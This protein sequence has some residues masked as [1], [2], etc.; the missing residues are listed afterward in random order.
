MANWVV[1]NRNDG[2]MKRTGHSTR[3]VRLVIPKFSRVLSKNSY[4]NKLG[5]LIIAELNEKK[6]GALPPPF[7]SERQRCISLPLLLTRWRFSPENQP[8][9]TL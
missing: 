3:P 4:S 6:R 7:S 5:T 9:P 2:V 8:Q 1:A